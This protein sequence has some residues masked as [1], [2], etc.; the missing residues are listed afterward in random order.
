LYDGIGD[1]FG[2]VHDTGAARQQV[3]SKT[4][5]PAAVDRRERAYLRHLKEL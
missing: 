1:T 3:G 5:L 4:I 2:L